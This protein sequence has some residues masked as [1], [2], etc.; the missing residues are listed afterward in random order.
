MTKRFFILFISVFIW[1]IGLTQ[2]RLSYTF[3]FEPIYSYRDYTVN[4]SKETDIYPSGKVVFDD[5]E[6]YYNETEKQSF[7][8]GMTIG[9]SYNLTEKLSIK[10]GLGYKRIQEKHTYLEPITNRMQINGTIEP[11]Y[12]TEKEAT[13]HFNNLT[14][15][16][17]FQYKLLMWEKMSLGF[18]VGSDFDISIGYKLSNY[19]SNYPANL[20]YEYAKVSNIAI[21]IKGGLIFNYEIQDNLSIFIQPEFARYITPNIKYNIQSEDWYCNIN[22]YNYYAQLRVGISFINKASR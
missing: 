21:N 8:F 16:I 20:K 10:S 2:S 15:P 4:Y 14:V 12:L 1:Q 22:Q 13:N 9:V 17:D 5:F 6:E 3:D 18:V 11:I 19:N 7:G